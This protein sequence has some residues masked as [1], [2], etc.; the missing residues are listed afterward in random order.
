MVYGV[1]VRVLSL[2]VFSFFWVGALDAPLLLWLAGSVCWGW[3]TLG[4]AELR[5]GARVAVRRLGC[6]RVFSH[7]TRAGRAWSGDSSEHVR[8]LFLRRCRSRTGVVRQLSRVSAG[9]RPCAQLHPTWQLSG[10][11]GCVGG[12]WR[13]QQTAVREAACDSG[14]R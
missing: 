14:T 12:G 9:V 11:S 3:S 1:A 10:A 2:V 6:G 5:S 4:N 13:R 7:L 8:R